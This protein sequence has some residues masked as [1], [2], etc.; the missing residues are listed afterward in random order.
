MN[1]KNTERK[2]E[3]NIEKYAIF[4]LLLATGIV[5]IGVIVDFLDK[6][7]IIDLPPIMAYELGAIAGIILGFAL[8]FALFVF[9]AKAIGK[10]YIRWRMRKERTQ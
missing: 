6:N 7:G 8:D 2:T 10:L 9:I 3:L 1:E 4:M 5:A